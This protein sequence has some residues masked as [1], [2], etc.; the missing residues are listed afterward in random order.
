MSTRQQVSTAPSSGAGP[1]SGW[2]GDK[3]LALLFIL[4]A[5]VLVGGLMYYPMASAF[6]ES[7][8][9]TSFLSPDPKF[10]GLDNYQDMIEDSGFWQIVRNSLT[11]TIFVVLLQN[12]A[13]M[14]TAVLLNQN[15]PGRGI[16]RAVVLLPWVLPGIVAALLWRFMYDPQ[17]GLINSI[18]ISLAVVDK[19]I[20]WLA[21]PSTAMLAV[22]LAAIWKG[23]PFSTVIYLAALQGVD[24]EQIE[25]AQMDGANAWQRF[26]HVVIPS[27]WHI[28]LL[29][30]LLTTIF[31]FNYFDMIWVTTKGGPLNSTHIFP[32]IIFQLGF[33][34]FQFGRAA[35]YGV[36]A[37]LMLAI[38]AFLYLRELR[39]SGKGV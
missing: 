34:E 24:N 39:P 6:S 5:V 13:G 38:F 23:F 1:R 2:L 28:I 26:I 14:A 27:V 22:V 10:I 7:L 33:G 32:T 18:L 19:G 35:A 8:F 21:Q 37:V 36:V 20:P 29:N 16:M 9:E 25:A 17:L 12:V 30:L 3:L 11:W 4:P 31:T 15:L